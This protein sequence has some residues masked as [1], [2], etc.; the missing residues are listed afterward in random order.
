[1]KQQRITI[2][3]AILICTTFLKAQELP[4]TPEY[5]EVNSRGHVFENFKGQ[6]SLY[7]FNGVAKLK[8]DVFFKTGVIEYDIY[9]TER[10]GFPGIQFRIEDESNYEEFYIRPHQ[11]GNLD[12]NQYTP[13]FNGLSGW[14]LYYGAGNAAPISYKMNAWNHIKLVL[15]E[16]DAEVY[17]NDMDTPLL[18]IPELK[19][20]PQA[21]TIRLSGGGPSP[22]HFAN[23]KL[24][25]SPNPAFKS[26]RKDLQSI[27]ENVIST[28]QVSN[29]FSERELE[30]IYDLNQKKF[31]SL[32]WTALKSERSG[33]ANLARVAQNEGNNNTVFAKITIVSD[34][35]QV[36]ALRYGFSD[37]ARVFFNGKLMASGNDGFRT[38]D[39]RF[40]GTMGY[41]DAVYLPLKKG[42]NELWIAVSENFGGWGLMAAFEN[43]LGVKVD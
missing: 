29:S 38:R 31:K 33:K 23:V 16:T 19:R 40:L 24:K 5:W 2:S 42:K 9:V 13:V 18:Y 39:Y 1:M 21:G 37:R 7:L 17:I 30:S 22:F 28:W 26:K 27:D 32:T 25:A 3:L 36:K 6:Q 35:V 12:A 43:K 15:A 4:L 20:A 10:R 14:Q 34:K 8:E 41:F 11:S